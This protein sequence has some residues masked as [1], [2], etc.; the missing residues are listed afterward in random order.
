MRRQYGGRRL[1][2]ER[3]IHESVEARHEYRGQSRSGDRRAQVDG[4]RP[5]KLVG[6][7]QRGTCRVTDINHS[8]A[9]AIA[10][11]LPIAAWV[12][13]RP[14]TVLSN[15]RHVVNVARDIRARDQ[16]R[17]RRCVGFRSCWTLANRTSS[18]TGSDSAW[19]S[20]ESHASS[21]TILVRQPTPATTLDGPPVLAESGHR[22]TRH[23]CHGLDLTAWLCRADSG[24]SG[25]VR[26][27]AWNPTRGARPL[28]SKPCVPSWPWWMA[29]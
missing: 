2:S 18:G 15:P 9:G 27:L 17:W 24:G 3:R 26:W 28:P 23:G 12:R 8:W 6:S 22:R 13:E 25:R 20:V 11:R 5:S 10:C 1:F 4:L 29:P 7:D 21:V 19:L 16:Q 14:W